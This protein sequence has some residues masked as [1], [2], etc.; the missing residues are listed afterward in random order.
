[1]RMVT[2]KIYY[3]DYKFIMEFDTGAETGANQLTVW[4]A[5][6]MAINDVPL[7]QF[8]ANQLLKALL[9][10]LQSRLRAQLEEEKRGCQRPFEEEIAELQRPFQTTKEQKGKSLPG[11]VKQ[12]IRN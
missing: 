7:S 4:V 12:K 11:K 2:D 1:M 9:E 8:S 6:K 3:G 10:P 5:E